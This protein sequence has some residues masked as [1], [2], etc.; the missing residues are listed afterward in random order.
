MT[1]KEK[2]L[3]DIKTKFGTYARFCRKAKI[4][5]YK[6]QRLRSEDNCGADCIK[7]IQRL[8]DETNNSPVKGE[9]TDSQRKKLSIRIAKKYGSGYNLCK[10]HPKFKSN[11]I[12]YVLTGKFKK[13]TPKSKEL[14]S[15][16][17]I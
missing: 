12:H 1:E 16:L 4:D 2:I 14:F 10:K 7:N 9:I 11:Y 6:F 15:L 5:Y 17:S 8:C 3:Q 13:L